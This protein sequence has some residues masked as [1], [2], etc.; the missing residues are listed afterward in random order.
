MRVNGRAWRY[1]TNLPTAQR[2]NRHS[3]PV[4]DFV[5][6]VFDHLCLAYAKVFST[7]SWI[8]VRT[9]SAPVP[10]AY[11]CIRNGL[12]KSGSARVGGVARRLTSVSI[13]FVWA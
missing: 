3:P 12:F 2:T 4:G 8:W 1:D 6:S 7:I 9:A 5:S 11:V 13:T 10:L